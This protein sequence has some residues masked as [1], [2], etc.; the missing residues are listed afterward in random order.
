[1]LPSPA[2]LVLSVSLLALAQPPRP[3]PAHAPELATLLR[4]MPAAIEANNMDILGQIGESMEQASPEVIQANL[5]TL[6]SLTEHP[7]D[8]VRGFAMIALSTLG[9]LHPSS[10]RTP[11][12]GSPYELLLPYLPRLLPRLTDDIPANRITSLM[13]F[14]P[15]AALR[16]T[17]PSL[18]DA[19][20]KALSD[21]DSITEVGVT[22][23]SP[24]QPPRQFAALGPIVLSP[25]AIAGS[26]CAVTP[27]SQAPACTLSPEVRNAILNFL[28]R[29][30]QT[31]ES[32][33]ETIHALAVTRLQ[34]QEVNAA[35]LPMLDSPDETVRIALLHDL[36]QFTFP[37]ASVPMVKARIAQ[38][39]TDPTASPKVRAEASRLLPCWSNDPQQL[40]PPTP[41]QPAQHRVQ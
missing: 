22:F 37:A 11:D 8:R 30:D 4:Q 33:A 31:P 29:S 10:A 23:A 19:L 14:T 27:P 21:P 3:A 28:G 12:H 32:L 18:L 39:A 17:P 20:L 38:L 5:P 25:L 24:G 40:C 6:V 9:M 15:M 7:N 16:P 34:G 2:I 26:S 41:V 35:L 1:V 36:D 13:L